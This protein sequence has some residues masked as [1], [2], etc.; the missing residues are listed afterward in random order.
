MAYD[1]A[2]AQLTINMSND[3]PRNFVLGEYVKLVYDNIDFAKETTKQTHVTNG[4]ITQKMA[5]QSEHSLLHCSDSTIINK[6]Q[7]TVDAPFSAIEEFN[8][9]EWKTP[10]FHATHEDAQSMSI[11]LNDSAG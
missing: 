11:A 8:L 9:G 1:A 6:S 5:A 3:I 2:L 4:I 7:R 10:T